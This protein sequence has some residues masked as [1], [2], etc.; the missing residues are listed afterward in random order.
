MYSW[1]ETTA[2]PD[3]TLVR[4]TAWVKGALGDTV[5]QAVWL[6]LGLSSAGLWVSWREVM[7]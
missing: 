1:L 3:G 7:P 5:M 2:H 4:I 6:D